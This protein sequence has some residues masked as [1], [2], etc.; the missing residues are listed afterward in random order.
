MF[1]KAHS[2]PGDESSNGDPSPTLG[3]HNG[4]TLKSFQGWVS[5]GF[6]CPL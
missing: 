1:L 3:I 4:G 6:A 2:L 5:L